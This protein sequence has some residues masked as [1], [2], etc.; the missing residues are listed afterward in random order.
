MELNGTF[1]LNSDP[2]IEKSHNVSYGLLAKFRK[3]LAV[4]YAD[5]VTLSMKKNRLGE[6]RSLGG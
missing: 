2:R 5:G 3:N 1:N 4:I 6:R